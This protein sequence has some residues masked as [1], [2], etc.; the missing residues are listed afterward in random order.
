MSSW[1]AVRPSGRSCGSSAG[2]EGR[3]ESTVDVELGMSCAS[4]CVNA[5]VGL[6]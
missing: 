2:V 4:R 3:G 6:G 1:C 5:F